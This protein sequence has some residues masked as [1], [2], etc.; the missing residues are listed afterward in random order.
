MVDSDGRI[1]S[2]S[3]VGLTLGMRGQRTVCAVGQA[4]GI[5]HE[6]AMTEADRH[7]LLRLLGRG[8]DNSPRRTSTLQESD[9]QRLRQLLGPV[10][11]G[12]S[13]GNYIGGIRNRLKFSA[14]GVSGGAAA[15][16]AVGDG[17]GHDGCLWLRLQI[18][19]EFLRACPWEV[20]S[21]TDL[22]IVR[23]MSATDA[24]SLAMAGT[25]QVL[26]LVGQ[27]SQAQENRQTFGYEVLALIFVN[28][29]AVVFAKLGAKLGKRHGT[30]VL[31]DLRSVDG[32]KSA[33]HG[34]KIPKNRV[35]NFG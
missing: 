16:A 31:H 25:L 30:R 1:S 26:L 34:Q 23:K 5:C 6:A 3:W 4:S 14:S 11:L 19:D 20:L 22:N 15:S 8:E 17:P 10:L 28:K 21:E 29:D 27:E 24:R 33:D 9:Y 32:L 7:D 12:G 18:E 13:V 2:S 35:E